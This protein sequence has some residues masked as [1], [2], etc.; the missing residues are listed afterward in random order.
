MT[1]LNELV[2][3]ST[4]ITTSEVTEEVEQLIEELVSDLKVMPEAIIVDPEAI[5]T[6]ELVSDL[7]D[8][9]V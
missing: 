4:E 5:Q 6:E 3:E 9:L 1:D 2:E 8:Y 7:V